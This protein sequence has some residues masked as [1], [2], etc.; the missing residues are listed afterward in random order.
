MLSSC[1]AFVDGSSP[2][3][4]PVLPTGVA[5]VDDDDDD[6]NEVDVDDDA[7]SAVDDEGVAG[8]AVAVAVA[9]TAA[10][11]EELEGEM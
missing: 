4:A 8:A 5:D 3:L 2:D 7:A 6:G 11:L 10:L 1:S 9:G